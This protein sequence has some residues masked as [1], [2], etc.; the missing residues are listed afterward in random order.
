METASD[1]GYE[2]HCGSHHCTPTYS[3]YTC[4][5]FLSRKISFLE[6]CLKIQR[7]HL[8][9]PTS[10]AHRKYLQRPGQSASVVPANK[11]SVHSSLSVAS[12]FLL[13]FDVASR[14][15]SAYLKNI[16][17]P[18]MKFLPLASNS[19]AP[20]I[21]VRKALE[22]ADIGAPSGVTTADFV[23]ELSEKVPAIFTQQRK[24]SETNASKRI[25]GNPCLF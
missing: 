9:P 20:Q 19:N 3:Q 7:F 8:V 11:V 5:S 24:A 6:K 13:S 12:G 25:T 10:K 1:L 17:Y 21:L 14:A 15:L 23:K 22:H 4:V 2:G 18:K 16:I